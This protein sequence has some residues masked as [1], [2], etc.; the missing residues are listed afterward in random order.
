[1]KRKSSEK[2]LKRKSSEKSLKRKA[3]SS[4]CEVEN[5]VG[6]QGKDLLND[7]E[8]AKR[9]DDQLRL[10]VALSLGDI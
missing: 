2:S 9:L 7:D 4:S 3:S 5:K 6:D 1:M 10:V 8:F